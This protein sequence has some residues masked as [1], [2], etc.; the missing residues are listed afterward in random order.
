MKENKVDVYKFYETL[1]KIIAQ[2]EGVE[3]KV[4]VTPKAERAKKEM[5]EAV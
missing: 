1:A 5:K 3:I 2:R 4:K